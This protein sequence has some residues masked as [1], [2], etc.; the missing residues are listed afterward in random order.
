MGLSSLDNTRDRENIKMGSSSNNDIPYIV[1]MANWSS[2][3]QMDASSFIHQYLDKK[4]Y[5]WQRNPT[6]GTSK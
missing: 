4:L 3:Q 2:K 6:G 5:G 1:N